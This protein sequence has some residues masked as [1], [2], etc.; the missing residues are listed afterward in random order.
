MCGAFRSRFPAPND[1]G[2]LPIENHRIDM[3]GVA[4]WSVQIAGGN[5]ESS[6]R[7]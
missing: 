7:T 1:S 5:I 4:S 2:Q 3:Q 6:A